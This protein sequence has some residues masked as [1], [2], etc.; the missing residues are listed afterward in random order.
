MIAQ[1]FVT[2]VSKR[3]A[4]IAQTI[5]V[6]SEGLAIDVPRTAPGK[7]KK[8]LIVSYIILLTHR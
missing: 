8:N 6:L 1:I 3:H 7:K 2:L 5:K 4:Y